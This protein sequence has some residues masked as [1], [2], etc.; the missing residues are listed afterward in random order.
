MYSSF[1]LQRNNAARDTAIIPAVNSLDIYLKVELPAY[2]VVLCL[3][4]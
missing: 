1:W 3:T 4:F 2:K